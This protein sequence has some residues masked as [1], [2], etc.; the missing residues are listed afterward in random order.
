MRA[1]LIDA[2]KR[3]VREV[4]YE[5]ERGKGAP[6]LQDHLGGYIEVASVWAA[7]DVL[8][9]D[10][11]GLYKPQMYFFRIDGRQDQ[12]FAGNGIVVGAERYDDKG[13]YIGTNAPTM[14]AKDLFKLVTW[15]TRDQVDSWAK[16]NASD[17]ASAVYFAKPDGS[18]ERMVTGHIGELYAQMPKPEPE[19]E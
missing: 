19:D 10:E 2:A 4:E 9:V 7:G 1:L 17:V 15:L 8:Y 14:T 12:P 6:T 13:D 5:Q 3:E 11:E 16:G 18:I